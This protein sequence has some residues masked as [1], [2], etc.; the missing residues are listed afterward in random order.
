[1]IKGGHTIVKKLKQYNFT[2]DS[3][4]FNP[5]EYCHRFKKVFYCCHKAS[6]FNKDIYLYF[7]LSQCGDGFNY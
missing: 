5:R 2:L 7:I 3:V 6:G 1:M 4:T